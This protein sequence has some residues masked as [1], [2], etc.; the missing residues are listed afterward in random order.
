MGRS[1]DE[2]PPLTR[3]ALD[4]PTDLNPTQP[5]PPDPTPGGAFAEVYNSLSGGDRRQF[6]VMAPN[7]Q[8]RSFNSFSEAAED[9]TISRVYIGDHF[10][11]T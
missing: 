9:V 3:D 4:V 1:R 6:T 8:T 10:S 11:F 5:T 2:A 7:G